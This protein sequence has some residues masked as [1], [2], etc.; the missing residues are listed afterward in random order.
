MNQKLFRKIQISALTPRQKKAYNFCKFS[1][2]LAEYGFAIIE[3]NESWQNADFI[4]QHVDG[5]TCLRD[6][7]EVV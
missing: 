1:S 3:L 7:T 6:A 5:E 4:A 2:A